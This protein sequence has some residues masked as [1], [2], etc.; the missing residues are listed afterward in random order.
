MES[1]YNLICREVKEVINRRH[2]EK[3]LSDPSFVPKG[4]WGTAPTGRIHVG[5]LRPMFVIADLV[6]AGCEVTILLAD[7]HAFLDSRKSPLDNQLRTQY[8]EIVITELL[9]LLEVDLSRVKFVVGS[10]FQE[11][12]EYTRDLLTIANSI[13]CSV[14]KD[15]GTEVVKQ[16]SDPKLTSLLYP[17]MQVLDEKYLGADFELGGVDQ[18]KIFAFGIDHI[19]RHTKHKITYLMNAMVQGLSGEKTSGGTTKMSSSST[20]GKLD[21]LDSPKELLNKIKKVYCLPGDIEDNTLLNLCKYILFPL[22]GRLNKTMILK[23]KFEDVELE[24]KNY[25]DLEN[26]FLNG[27][28]P[29]DF[30]TSVAGAIGGVLKPLRDKFLEPEMIILLKKAYGSG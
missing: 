6:S 20:I 2:L 18:R 28:H 12:R 26:L 23:K 15:A 19:H 10:S 24:V 5:Y 25:V 9:K 8:Y 22:L 21:L 3:L 16:D 11:T 14:A 29:D 13:N 30:K 7:I 1:R 4:Y 17:I 27:L